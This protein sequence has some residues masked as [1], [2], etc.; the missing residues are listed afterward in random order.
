M[1]AASA[2]GNLEKYNRRQQRRGNHQRSL[3][4]SG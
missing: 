1:A 3:M 2:K 4:A